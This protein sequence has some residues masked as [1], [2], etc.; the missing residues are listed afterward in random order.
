M[1][2]A[3]NII[4]ADTH[5]MEPPNFW[6]ERIDPVYRSSAP[7]MVERPEGRTY[8]VEGEPLT[9]S[10]DKSYPMTAKY[11][12]ASAEAA[13]RF[14]MAKAT[15]YSPASRLEDMDAYGV[16]VQ[17]LYPT[18][19]GQLLGREFHDPDLLVACCR[20]YNDWSADY[21]AT[22]PARLRWAAVVPLQD[23]SSALEEVRRT[24][25]M[26]AGAFFVRPQPVKGR[27]LSHRDYVPLW[28]EIERLDKPLCI[29]D[30]ASCQLPSFGDR[31]QTHTA[32]HI[33]SHPFEA[34]AA[35]TDLIWNGVFERFPRLTV[36]H[37]EADSGWLPYWLQRMEQHWRHL[38]NAEHPDMLRA[39]TEYF[40]RNVFVSCRGDEPTLKSVVELVGDSELLIKTDY[41]HVDGTWP[42]GLRRAQ[43]AAHSRVQHREDPVEERRSGLSHRS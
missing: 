43:A 34:M 32:G 8:E 19:T 33:I 21:C 30:S 38:G 24:G 1:G 23:V 12:A 39:P 18:V 40:K 31:M 7:R 27:N 26:G 6:E 11:F 36:V 35:M 20:T 16:G 29:H 4:D 28:K 5:Q 2:D 37:V 3:V 17:V 22:A 42:W 41:P 13:A 10:A 14:N 25:A 15:G 9:R